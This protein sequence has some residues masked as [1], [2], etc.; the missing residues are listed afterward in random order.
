M[1]QISRSVGF[2]AWASGLELR[3]QIA[4]RGRQACMIKCSSSE[5]QADVLEISKCSRSGAV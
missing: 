5:S 1:V 2:M 3:L 4:F